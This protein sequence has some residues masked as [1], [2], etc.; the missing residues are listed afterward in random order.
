MILLFVC[1]QSHVNAEFCS[2]ELLVFDVL[3]QKKM[4]HQDS[5]RIFLN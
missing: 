1:N 5:L 4:T 2:S 3:L